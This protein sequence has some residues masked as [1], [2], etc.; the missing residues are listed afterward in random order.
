MLA[1]GITAGSHV[2]V[3][4]M[5]ALRY[6]QADGGQ[7]IM[8]VRPAQLVYANFKHIQVL[9][10]SRLQDGVPLYKLKILDTLIDRLSPRK[11]PATVD[12]GSIDA[13]IGEMS[14]GPHRMTPGS[15]SRETARAY[16]AGFFPTP[17]A[18]VNLVA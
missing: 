15:A 4:S 12:A 14:L 6:A 1:G 2:G 11:L 5:T 18:F 9:P 17:G 8:P 3:V 13:L 16:S 7:A 10:D